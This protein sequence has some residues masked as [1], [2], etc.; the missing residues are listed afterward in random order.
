M[1]ETEVA[2]MLYECGL[3]LNGSLVEWSCNVSR[4]G[5]QQRITGGALLRQVLV[6]ISV[7]GQCRSRLREHQ[8]GGR[9]ANIGTSEVGTGKDQGPSGGEYRWWRQGEA[10]REQQQEAK[11]VDL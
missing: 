8:A 4:R 9:C 7:V 1:V 5:S 2:T 6:P 11:K 10:S 3:Y